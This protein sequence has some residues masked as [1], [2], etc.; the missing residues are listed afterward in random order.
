[1]SSTLI[2]IIIGIILYT[3]IAE[4]LKRLGY[5]P[6]YISVQGPI[7]SVETKRGEK[8]L[9][10]I[11]RI[12]ER[13]WRLWGNLGI[14]M[15]IIVMFG[16]FIVMVQSTLVVYRGV[17]QRVITNPEDV[18]VIPGVNQFLPLGVAPEIIF[19]LVVGLVIHEGGHGIY[20]RLSNIGIES[21]GVAL[22]ALIPLGAFVQPNDKDIEDVD[23]RSKARMYVAGVT[24]NIVLAVILLLILFIPL[25]YSIAP[26][27]GAAV[28]GVFPGTPAEDAGIE[29]GDVIVSVNGEEIEGNE[30]LEGFISDSTDEEV[31]IE[32]ADGT[33]TTV[34]R[35]VVIGGIFDGE[36]L[37]FESG[38]RIAAVN[39][40]QVRTVPAFEEAVSD[41]TTVTLENTNGETEEYAIGAR[42][43]G[44]TGEG[45]LDKTD[46]PTESES[47]VVT[48][49]GEERVLNDEDASEVMDELDPGTEVKV[50]YVGDGTEETIEIV[51][52]ENQSLG[53][54]LA[55]GYNG[56]ILMDFGVDLYPAGELL[57]MLQGDSISEFPIYLLIITLLPF[58]GAID[59]DM[60]YNFAGFV[61]EM[62]NFYTTTG[63]LAH[64]G[65]PVV[66][67]VFNIVFWCGWINL[68]LGIFNCVPAYPLDGGHLLRAAL[69][70]IRSFAPER[71]PDTLVVFIPRFTTLLCIVAF[72]YLLFG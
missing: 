23:N 13:G 27:A 56:I 40:E 60:G 68:Q 1:M 6:D 36:E 71:I 38:D 30:R 9:T 58:L 45:A 8:V 63:P 10:R 20:C 47:V 70:E 53:V 66:F 37:Q 31:N 12:S 67:L 57:G 14:G 4:G 28:G 72:V 29:H 18:L 39:G 35:E 62:T 65:D 49:I 7:A 21:M 59:P 3:V 55:P 61:G 46:L 25:S 17:Q 16:I 2:W 22:F 33:E 64:L 43:L 48:H 52:P 51:V 24:N 69:E 32:L 5:L 50:Q 42:V 19:G 54:E 15:S 41:E 11:S 34:K 44:I 26:V